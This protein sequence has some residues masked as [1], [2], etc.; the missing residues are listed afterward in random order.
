MMCKWP[1]YNKC[2]MLYMK[3]IFILIPEK[4]K[5]EKATHHEI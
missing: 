2:P 3:Y 5:K 4:I 1:M